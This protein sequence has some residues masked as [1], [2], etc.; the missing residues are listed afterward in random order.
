MEFITAF[1]LSFLLTWITTPLVIK[2]AFRY[3]LVD[4]PNIR[5]HPATTHRGI[6]PRAGGIA[7]LLGILIPSLL[8]LPLVKSIIGILL[9]A[10][11][12]V[13]IGVWD[14]Y[15][16]LS[17]YVRFLGNV[18]TALIVVGVGVGVPFIT[19]PVDGVIRLDTVRWQFTFFGPHSILFWADIFAILWIV[20]TMNI[21]GWS[22]GVDGQMPGF[23]TITALIIGIHSLNF[24]AHDLSQTVVAQLAF[25]S[26]GA[27]LGFLPWNF[28]PQKIMPGYGGKTLAGLLLATLA[29]L[30]GNKVGTALLV[31]AVPIVDAIFTLARRIFRKKSP[32]R[33]D[34]QHLHHRL[35]DLGWGRRRIALLYWC[36][37]AILGLLTLTLNKQE[38]VFAFLVVSVFVVMIL[39][40]LSFILDTTRLKKK[41]NT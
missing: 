25:I 30:S 33:G 2:A 14:D 32:F 16:D 38:K 6:I 17:P 29:I 22:S 34:R 8:F 1:I 37:S 20:W 31:L 3:R 28:Y 13:V 18:L 40:W 19:N 26:A 7:L 5:V 36:I 4:D 15:Q 24:S 9:A 35:L 39:T 23:V 12:T 10:T 21:V 11:L 41:A 27:Y